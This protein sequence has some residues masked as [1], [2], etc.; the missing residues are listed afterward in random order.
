MN[1]VYHARASIKKWG[2]CL[3]DYLPIHN[4]FDASKEMVGDIRHR[5]LRHHTQGIFEA[6]R[7]FGSEITLSTGKK[8]PVREIGELH[9]KQDLGYLPTLSDWLREMPMKRWMSGQKSVKI[10]H[11]LNIDESNH[12]DNKE[13]MHSIR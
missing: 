5:A 3:E 11:K 13:D 1:A 7:V 2:G 6:E 9:V 4:W 10:V 8:V 12:E